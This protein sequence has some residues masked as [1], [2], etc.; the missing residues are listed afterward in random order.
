[1]HYIVNKTKTTLSLQIMSCLPVL[2]LIFVVFRVPESSHM[3]RY[4]PS[5]GAKADGKGGGVSAVLY[6]VTILLLLTCIYFI[7]LFMLQA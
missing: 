1:V 4:F 5:G 2:V 7:C 6:M 3:F